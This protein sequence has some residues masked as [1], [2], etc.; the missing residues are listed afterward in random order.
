MF[1]KDTNLCT[2]MTA[3]GVTTKS[4][5]FITSAILNLNRY[6]RVVASVS[7]FNS[8]YTVNNNYL[9]EL[10]QFEFDSQQSK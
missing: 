9:V 8:V 1:L 4:E 5:A 2:G 10:K 7:P 6:A 3:L